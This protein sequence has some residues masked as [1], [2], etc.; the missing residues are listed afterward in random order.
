MSI[1]PPAAPVAVATFQGAGTLS[2]LIARQAT[3]TPTAIAVSGDTERLDYAELDRRANQLGRHLAELGVG[4]ESL[5]AVNLDRGVDLVVALLGVWR[6]GAA[7]L[8]L[9]PTH[10]AERRRRLLAD[11]GAGVLLTRDALRDE[12]TPDRVVCL[13]TDRA[14]IAACPDT[15]AVPSPDPDSVAYAIYTSG[16]TGHPKGVLIT[17][18]GIGNRVTW[19]IREHDL[20]PGDRVLQKTSVSFDA[21]GWEFFAPLASGGTVVLAP[22]GAHRDP[23]ALVAAVVRHRITVLQGVP[24]VFARLVDQPGWAD[25][26]SL[27]LVFSAGEPLHADLCRRLTVTPDVRVWNTYGPTECAI[28]VTAHPVDTTQSAGPVPIGRPLPGVRVQVLG[29]DRRPVPVGVVGELYIGGANLGRGYL[30]RPDLTADRFVP[31]EYGPP[32]ARLYRTGDQVRWRADR[33]LEFVGRV[34]H[35]LKVNGVRIEPAE[36]EAVLAAH[37]DVQAAVVVGH[38]DPAG[39]R[40]LAAYVA[41]RRSLDPATLR[42]FCVGRLP[43]ALVP[44]V[45]QPVAEFPLTASGKIDRS[46]LPAIDTLDRPALRAPRTAAEH[47]VAAIWRD[48]LGVDQV[49]VDDDFYQLGG[50]SLVTLTLESQLSAAGGT[51]TLR[52]L[53][54]HTTVS[55]QARLLEA[56]TPATPPVLPVGRDRPLP[57]S[58]AQHRLWMLDQLD[59]GSKEW[60]VPVH[61]RLSAATH[62][63]HV[64]AALHALEVRHEPLRTRYLVVDGVAR[65][66]VVAPGTVDLDVRDVS[67]GG[68][69][70]LIT[71]QLGRGFDLHTGPLWRA[72]LA[73]A[74]GRDHLLVLAVHHIAS[75][76]G[77]ADVLERDLRELC[78]AA[79]QGRPADLPDLPVQY[80]DYAVWQQRHLTDEVVGRELAYWREALAGVPQ[81]EL[82]LDRPRPARRDAQ[83]SMLGFTITADVAG[84]LT[85]VGRRC[86]ASPFM[87]LLTGFATVLAR[88]T[89]QWDVPIGTPTSGHRPAELDQIAGIFLNP[90]ALRCTLDPASGFTRA[91]RE[92]RN[93]TVAALAHQDLPFDRVVYDLVGERDLSRTPLYQVA[94]NYQDGGITGRMADDPLTIDALRQAS[95]VAKTDLTVH[96]WPQ[97]DGSLAGAVEYAT[98]LFDEATVRR[99]ADHFVR[100]LGAAA[101]EPDARLDELDPFSAEERHQLLHGWNG[102]TVPRPAT[103][104]VDLFE[105][106]RAAAPQ[107]VALRHGDACTSYAELDDRANRF[108]N[109]LRRSSVAPGATVAVLLARGPDLVAAILGCWKAGAACLPLDPSYP[110]E[111]I[112][113]LLDTAGVGLAVTDSRFAD[114][115]AVPTLQVDTHRLMVSAEPPTAPA[116]DLDPAHTAYVLFTSGSTGRPKG[117][118]LSHAAVTNFLA[119]ATETEALGDRGGRPAGG[120]APLFSTIAFDLSISNLWGPLVAGQP[121]TLLPQEFD[122]TQLGA[123]LLAAGPYDRFIMTPPHLELLATQ[124]DAA[125]AQRLAG[126]LWVAGG[127]L[128]GSVATKWLDMLG[129]GGLINS[130]GPT[131]T[132]VI[133]SAY[134]VVEP[135]T[136]EIVSI[137]RPMANTVVRILDDEMRLLPVGAVGELYIGG[138]CLATG[139]L[140]RPGL[141]AERFVPDPY[142]PPGTRLYRSGDRGHWRPDGTMAFVGRVDDQVKVRGY[143]IEPGEI[144]AVVAKHPRVRDCVVL[145]HQDRLVAFYLGEATDLAAYCARQLP[146]FMV[147]SLF[148]PVERIPLNA[149][150]KVDRNALRGRLDA[151]LADGIADPTE[152]VAPQTVVEKRVAAIWAE[153]LDGRIGATTDFFLLGG[154]SVLAARLIAGLQ[155]EFDLD[156]PIRLAFEHPT[157]RAQA[158]AIEDLIRAEV[159]AL[160]AADLTHDLSRS[161]EYPA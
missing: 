77:T 78:A 153:L 101:D 4:P 81:L 25:C 122:L 119:C 154:H 92:V 47:T 102:P 133:M 128:R 126:Q 69:A 68:L 139:Y 84:A 74:T 131:E 52:D 36:V 94:L 103:T 7:Y 93:R 11:S 146:D 145:A 120:G 90:V 48:L 62:P 125:Q 55:A 24:S 58:A 12:A 17:H 21:A 116:R 34:D 46:A 142:G 43:E 109:H 5:V 33:S 97:P 41:G 13:D 149:N 20:G 135:Q 49:G 114:R 29:A 83:G 72:G 85:D 51:V 76:A 44:A 54:T 31:D 27:R 134:P 96:L 130:Y 113:Y 66:Q 124:V 26:T 10:P 80:A 152:F 95:T 71:E 56:A 150:G 64:R 148:V 79:A 117:V 65:Q 136:S 157:V 140:G 106:R 147:P 1:V 59:P 151:A 61:V 42:A 14:R 115:F 8:P 144:S 22:D 60:V 57:L 45:F 108:A 53:L 88:Y 86:A 158:I 105:A 87:T 70:E 16:S 127:V 91:V 75:D 38:T 3:L 63:D 100:L 32:G 9:D 159:D 137:G 107:A 98:A 23:A 129:P 104:V 156:L 141:T 6:A 99:F 121:V 2:E 15:A 19:T 138:A 132:T 111:R 67:H 112:D 28:D 160:D 35:Q 73:V 89:G 50:S 18:R 82:P 110:A 37:P 161:E 40:Q 155:E 143:R 118:L 39:R 123:L 30:H